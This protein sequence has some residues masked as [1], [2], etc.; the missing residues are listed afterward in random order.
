MYLIICLVALFFAAISELSAV[1]VNKEITRTIDATSAVV[2]LTI[3]IKAINVNGEYDITF[4]NTQAK[5]V[6]FLSATSK[7]KALT[8]NAPVS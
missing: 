6:A 2:K 5:H 8:V 1:I 4:Q 3:D 7:G